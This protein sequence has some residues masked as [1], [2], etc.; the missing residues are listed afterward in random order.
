MDN[1]NIFSSRLKELRKSLNLSQNALAESIGLSPM[2]ISTYETAKKYPSIGVVK[3]IAETYSV[4]IDWLCGLTDTKIRDPQLVTYADLYQ[5]LFAIS[6]VT[7][8]KFLP[9]RI[10]ATTLNGN[11]G[12]PEPYTAYIQTI[13]FNN[14]DIEAFL[15]EWEKMKTLYD[16]DIIDNE[17][18]S[19]WMEKTLKKADKQNLDGSFNYEKGIPF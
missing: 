4:S 13:Y 1:S 17:V 16:T 15:E 14:T 5:I 10:E 8:I 11:T 18:Y 6:K 7:D 3:K 12:Y 9:N 2:A 19:L